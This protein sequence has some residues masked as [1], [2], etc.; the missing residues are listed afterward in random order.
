VLE[1]EDA[2]GYENLVW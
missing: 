1:D 2:D